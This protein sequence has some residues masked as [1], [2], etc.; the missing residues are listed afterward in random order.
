MFFPLRR[1]CPPRGLGSSPAWRGGPWGRGGGRWRT[2]QNR[3][4][5]SFETGSGV[6]LCLVLSV[7]QAFVGSGLCRCMFCS[8]V[9]RVSHLLSLLLVPDVVRCT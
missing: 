5:A 6:V 1:R 3:T 8:D 7:P 2:P 9:H 4:F